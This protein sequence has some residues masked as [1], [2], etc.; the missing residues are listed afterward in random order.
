MTIPDNQSGLTFTKSVPGPALLTAEVYA[1][2]WS[3]HRITWG[4]ATVVTLVASL[5]ARDATPDVVARLVREA[6]AQGTVTHVDRHETRRAG[7]RRPP[8]A[9]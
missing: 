7:A 4:P 5:D 9:V 8:I 6:T 1:G 3:L 2:E